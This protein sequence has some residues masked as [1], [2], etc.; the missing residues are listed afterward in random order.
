MVLVS[1]KRWRVGLRRDGSHRQIGAPSE[2]I[3][4]ILRDEARRVKPRNP[5][6]V[7][8]TLRGFAASIT[9][10]QHRPQSSA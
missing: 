5:N 10:N 9:F 2:F 1:P 3:R 8:A 7:R 4:P 6:F